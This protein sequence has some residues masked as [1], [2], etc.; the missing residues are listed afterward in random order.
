MRTQ[1]Y[2]I[3]NG[4]HGFTLIELLIVVAIIGI[5]AAIAVPNF[6][7]A[8]MRSKLAATQEDFRNLATVFESYIIDWHTYPKGAATNVAN[9]TYGLYSVFTTPVPYTGAL[10][11]MAKE[12]FH[13]D[14]APNQDQIYYDAM[15]GRTDRRRCIYNDRAAIFADIER[16]CWMLDSKGPDGDDDILDSPHFPQRPS[17]KFII[18]SPTNGLYSDGDLFRV[19]GGYIPQWVMPY[20]RE[21]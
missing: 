10:Y 3:N 9:I 15:F 14:V 5:L 1:N 17:N 4:K 12:R 8:Q 16:D 11:A 20:L 6:L 13:T 7:A 18:Y 2:T 21:Q 19:G